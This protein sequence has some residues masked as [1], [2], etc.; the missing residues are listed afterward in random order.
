MYDVTCTGRRVVASLSIELYDH[1]FD[2]LPVQFT[3]GTSK[4]QI[5]Y[6]ASERG[7]LLKPS[8]CHQFVGGEG[9]WPNRHIT[10][11]VAEKA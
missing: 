9:V 2:T 7:G 4:Y 1:E 6:D 8:E 5:S 10:F 3:K 11:I